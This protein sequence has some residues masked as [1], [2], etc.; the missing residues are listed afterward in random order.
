MASIKTRSKFGYLT[1]N[2]MLEKIKSGEFDAYDIIFTSDSKECYVVSPELIPI[3]VKSKVYI[4]E[5]KL[6]AEEIL[7]KNTDTYKGQIVSILSDEKYK[8]YIVNQKDEL[9]YVEPICELIDVDYDTLGNRPIINMVGTLDNSI[10]VSNLNT[11][12]YKIV[13]QY[14]I[15]DTDETI[16][17]AASDVI[18]LV[19][20]ENNSTKIRRITSDEIVNYSITNGISTSSHLITEE[21]LKENNYVQESYINTKISALEKSLKEELTNYITSTLDGQLSQIIDEKID[22]KIDEKLD[23]KLTETDDSQITSLFN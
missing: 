11:G 4:F 6:E 8:A 3:S 20:K 22:Q 23:E 14:K 2:R 13:G 16:Y 9:F 17:L 1:Y 18:F 5:S 10:T 19:N 7:N 21:Y 15:T 12:I